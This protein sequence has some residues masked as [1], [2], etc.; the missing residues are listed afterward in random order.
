M[1]RASGDLEAAERHYN[2]ALRIGRAVDSP[3][4]A[5]VYIGNL[6]ELAL[7]RE[8]WGTAEALAR[9]ALSLSEKLGRLELI[10]SDCR[11]L[12]EALVRQGKK[13]DALSYALRA[14][15]TFTQL[16]SP[17]LLDARKVLTECE[18]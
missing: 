6:A 1:Q 12:A 14:V 16:G 17:K 2:E 4:S 10:A 7:D 15:D 11:Y 5:A 3:R 8:N 13:T 9:E 18:S